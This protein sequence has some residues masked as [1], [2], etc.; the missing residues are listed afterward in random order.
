MGTRAGVD[1]LLQVLSML[2]LDSKYYLLVHAPQAHYKGL[3]Y[4]LGG[5]LSTWE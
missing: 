4:V 5:M 2:E 3:S 1:H